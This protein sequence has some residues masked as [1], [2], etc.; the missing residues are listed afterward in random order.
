LW[1]QKTISGPPSPGAVSRSAIA[2]GRSM[3]AF[4][5]RPELALALMQHALV[6]RGTGRGAEA[7]TGFGQAVELLRPL[8]ARDPWRNTPYLCRALGLF[9]DTAVRHGD[10]REAARA[11]TE[12]ATT[13]AA[14]GLLDEAL[15]LST[16]AVE[17]YEL[18]SARHADLNPL[19]RIASPDQHAVL[20]TAKGRPGDAVG[21]LE[22]A[23]PVLL[24]LGRDI[25]REHRMV[26]GGMIGLL[27]QA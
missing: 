6:L 20:L 23:V 12:A 16:R 25:P 19:S 9:A 18:L 2:Y 17:L 8:L 4:F 26:L 22:Q 3:R 15:E 5:L 7:L 10:P 24:A 11:A 27:R 14:V 13:L 1:T 21:P